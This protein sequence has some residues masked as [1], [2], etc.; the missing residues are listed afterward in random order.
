VVHFLPRSSTKSFLG[1]WIRGIDVEAILDNPLPNRVAG[2][3]GCK[4]TIGNLSY[5]TQ[6][7]NISK[8]K[9]QEDQVFG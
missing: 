9:Y 6:R 5:S 4:E 2:R 3:S 8:R 1:T 7:T